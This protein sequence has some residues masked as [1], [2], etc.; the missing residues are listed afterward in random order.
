V[1]II[2]YNIDVI[3]YTILETLVGNL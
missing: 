3:N 2:D 1:S